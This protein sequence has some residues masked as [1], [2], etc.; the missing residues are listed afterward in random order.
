MLTP[1]KFWEYM[2]SEGIILRG[3]VMA[4]FREFPGV[5]IDWKKIQTAFNR[6][7]Q[8][9]NACGRW[10]TR[11]EL[12]KEWKAL[13]PAEAL[14][15]KQGRIAEIKPEFES[16]RP[17]NAAADANGARALC[18][19]FSL[20]SP[21]SSVVEAAAQANEGDIKGKAVAV[22]A[23]GNCRMGRP[24]PAEE[25][26]GGKRTREEGDNGGAEGRPSKR[27]ASEA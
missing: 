20:A 26:L 3:V 8:G 21:G 19:T 10:R 16:Q 7:N 12:R 25:V 24:V 27:A 2:S 9:E 11:T 13:Y 15:I 5:D 1:E 14:A 22:P 23:N 18:H 17:A 6:C 4:W